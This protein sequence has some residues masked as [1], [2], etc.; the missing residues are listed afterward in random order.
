[1]TTLHTFPAAEGCADSADSPF[2]NFR[3]S[4]ARSRPRP[5]N[6]LELA[7]A[8]HHIRKL[9]DLRVEERLEEFQKRIGHGGKP[10]ET[11]MQAARRR[12]V[13]YMKAELDRPEN[14]TL[15]EASAYCGRSDRLVNEARQRGDYYALV[16][17]GNE[18]G[19]RYPRWQFDAPLARLVPVLRQLDSIGASCWAR[20]HFLLQP[21]RLLAGRSPRDVILDSSADLGA[22][23]RAVQDHF[24][25]DQG[26]A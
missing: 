3:K 14:L 26:A 10:P 19:F 11:P 22:I 2:S 24:L 1:M 17:E 23:E 12:G 9:V 13:S 20:H 5:K 4:L 7:L 21:S 15:G 18:R 8:D 6:A 25:A 16:M